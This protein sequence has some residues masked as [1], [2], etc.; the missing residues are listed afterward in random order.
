[1]IGLVNVAF[2][3]QSRYFVAE[4]GKTATPF[5]ELGGK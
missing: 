3:F 2:W 4:L 5:P 1:M